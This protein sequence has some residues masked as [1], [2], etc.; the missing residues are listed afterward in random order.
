MKWKVTWWIHGA[1][2]ICRGHDIVDAKILDEHNAEQLID[3][4]LA[5]NIEMVGSFTPNLPNFHKQHADLMCEDR[6]TEVSN[7]GIIAVKITGHLGGPSIGPENQVI[8][9]SH[10]WIKHRL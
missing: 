2:R 4:D 6:H 1:G 9:C 5:K 8:V 3:E 7:W 10:H